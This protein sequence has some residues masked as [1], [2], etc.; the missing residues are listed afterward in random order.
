M[1]VILIFILCMPVYNQISHDC[2][3]SS[4]P[5]PIHFLKYYLHKIWTV[6]PQIL[7]RINGGIHHSA[8][9]HPG[10][11][12]NYQILENLVQGH[13]ILLSKILHW[14]S[15]LHRS[16][17]PIHCI[18]LTANNVYQVITRCQCLQLEFRVCYVVFI[19]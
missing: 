6:T 5:T 3:Y 4:I 13:S 2:K 1:S 15:S 7:F 17:L 19:G 16:L 11:P 10:T 14:L 9:T 18:Q 12:P 8:K